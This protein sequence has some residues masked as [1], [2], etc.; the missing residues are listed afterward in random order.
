MIA[1]L[2]GQ[3]AS[4]SIDHVILDVGGVGYRVFI[5]LSTYYALPESGAVRLEIVTSVREDAFLLYGFLSGEEKALFCLLTGVSGIGPK[6]ALNI[7][8]HAAPA[9]LQAAI[10]GG[11][12]RQL[13]ALPG[14]GKKTAERLILEL[15]EK[16]GRLL[17][18]PAGI[19][20]RTSSPAAPAVSACDDALSA[21]VNLGYKEA[22]AKKA[23]EA[24]DLP[25]EA[26]VELILR[27]ALKI[28]MR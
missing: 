13:S 1:L 14:I 16:I 4:K 20:P 21:L 3:L 17:P 6:L 18:A 2:N 5:P 23:I 19:A 26:P 27:H 22:Q 28:L 8:S 12:V 7:L 15:K 25:A 10:T 24:L 9:T 11:D